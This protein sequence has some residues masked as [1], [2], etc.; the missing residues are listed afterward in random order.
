MSRSGGLPLGCG[1]TLD[2][3]HDVR[4]LH[5]KK[6][7]AI[8]LDLGPGP[9][10]EQHAVAGLKIEGNKLPALVAGPW[11]DA[12]DLA[13]LRLLLG[14]VRNDDAALRF[15]LAFNAADNDTVVQRTKFHSGLLSL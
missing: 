11:P 13:L 6:V 12:D 8:D 2:D 7:L 10:A 5:D 15:L 4:L 3:A 14:G 1:S 9:L